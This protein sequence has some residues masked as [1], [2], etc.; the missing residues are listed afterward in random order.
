MPRALV[1]C[2]YLLSFTVQWNISE[3]IQSVYCKDRSIVKSFFTRFTINR[4]KSD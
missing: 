2:L 3:L 4:K 1:L